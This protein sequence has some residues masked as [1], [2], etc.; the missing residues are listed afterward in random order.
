[1]Q[2]QGRK[3]RYHLQTRVTLVDASTDSWEPFGKPIA[4]YVK[5]RFLTLAKTSHR[6]EI[7]FQ[8]L[9]GW[10][11]TEVSPTHALIFQQQSGESLHLRHSC[12][13][14]ATGTKE[15]QLVHNVQGISLDNQK[16]IVVNGKLEAFLNAQGKTV[17]AA[18][19]CA[20]I[21]GVPLPPIAA[22][23]ETQVGILQ[24]EVIVHRENSL[25][26]KS[27]QRLRKSQTVILNISTILSLDC[28]T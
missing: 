11:V 3:Y 26:S 15:R 1:M 17:Y 23:A 5:N 13:I 24:A 9:T 25:Q 18:G 6:N 19:D 7:Q 14:F 20:A 2:N 22:V 16:K 4:N 21:E 27:Q 28:S 8:Y 10:K 12:L